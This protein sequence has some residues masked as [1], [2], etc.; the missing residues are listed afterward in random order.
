[1][2]ITELRQLKNGRYYLTLDKN[3]WGTGD[4]YAQINTT[5]DSP[6]T[7]CSDILRSVLVHVVNKQPAISEIYRPQTNE[8]EQIE[9]FLEILKQS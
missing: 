1:M 4:Y 6:V 2:I 9:N 5:L 7:L 3:L 8:T